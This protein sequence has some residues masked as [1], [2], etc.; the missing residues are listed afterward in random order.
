MINPIDF[1]GHFKKIIKI[2]ALLRGHLVRKNL[3]GA[4]KGIASV[5]NAFKFLFIDGKV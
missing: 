3:P 1:E 2:Q 4:H 5:K